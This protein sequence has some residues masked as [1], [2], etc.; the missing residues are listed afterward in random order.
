MTFQIRDKTEQ[1][2]ALV[3]PEN[4]CTVEVGKR[5]CLSSTSCALKR[6]V[7]LSSPVHV[8]FILYGDR[9]ESFQYRKIGEFLQLHILMS[10]GQTEIRNRPNGLAVEIPDVYGQTTQ[11]PAKFHK[12]GNAK[13]N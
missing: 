13:R 6:R 1:N 5:N 10:F 9:Q 12:F 8:W 4:V 2:H 3:T 11:I 7:S